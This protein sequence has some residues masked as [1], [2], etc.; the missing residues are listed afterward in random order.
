[1]VAGVELFY[2]EV[3]GAQFAFVELLQVGH[4][5]LEERFLFGKGDNRTL[6][7]PIGIGY[8]DIDV[9]PQKVVLMRILGHRFKPTELA[10]I[11]FVFYSH[12]LDPLTATFAFSTVVIELTIL[13]KASI[14]CLTFEQVGGEYRFV[15]DGI[16]GV[17]WTFVFLGITHVL[18]P[19]LSF[20]SA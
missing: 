8:S 13:E 9:R 19:L 1:V 15:S 12:L 17:G 14:A 2:H 7:I 6:T 20:G 16:R 3:K 18:Q 5:L 4:G 10:I 11:V